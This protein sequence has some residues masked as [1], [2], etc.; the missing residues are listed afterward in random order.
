MAPD[1]AYAQPRGLTR[2][3]Q[4]QSRLAYETDTIHVARIAQHIKKAHLPDIG[5]SFTQH[6]TTSSKYH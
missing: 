3:P 2:A 6:K 4:Q 1:Y 5:G